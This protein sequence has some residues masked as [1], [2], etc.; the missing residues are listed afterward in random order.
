MKIVTD[1]EK[2]K[3]ML[4]ER[5]AAQNVKTYDLLLC[6]LVSAYMRVMSPNN[7][8]ATGVTTNF[9]GAIEDYD[10]MVA[11]GVVMR[12]LIML[13][14]NDLCN[15]GL[16]LVSEVRNHFKQVYPIIDEAFNPGIQTVIEI[17]NTIKPDTE[18]HGGVMYGELTKMLHENIVLHIIRK[19]QER[20]PKTTLNYTREAGQL[21]MEACINVSLG[22]LFGDVK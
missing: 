16:Q 18:A 19:V 3:T 17:L 7:N 10:D 14:N 6:K 1:I 15:L 21:P 4:D 9:A 12:K 13:I 20:Y 5:D 22:E 2:I 8:I 11:Y